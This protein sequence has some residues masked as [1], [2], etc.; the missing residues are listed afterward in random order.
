MTS[1]A[2]RR[3]YPLVV[4]IIA[5]VVSTSIADSKLKRRGRYVRTDVEK[6]VDKDSFSVELSCSTT[7]SLPVLT[8]K[9][10]TIRTIHEVKMYETLI[11]TPH[12]AAETG[13]VFREKNE[14]KVVPGEFM[15]GE[16]SERIEIIDGKP[17]PNEDFSINGIFIFKT[18]ADGNCL[19]K[20]Q[21]ILVFMDDLSVNS[22]TL[23][24][25]HDKLGEKEFVLTRELL[26]RSNQPRTVKPTPDTIPTVDILEAFGLDFTQLR[27]IGR[28]GLELKIDLP[29]GAQPNTIITAT[30]TATNKGNRTIGTLMV[31]T[32]S[33]EGWLDG[34]MFYFGNLEPGKTMT[35][36]RQF[37]VPDK[38][39]AEASHVAFAVWN[40]LGR[41]QDQLQAF[42]LKRR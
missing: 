12:S 26:K 7:G 35:F 14:I 11:E 6:T 41:Q 40:L 16:R 4:A 8:F 10:Q 17:L 31:R 34:K 24:F 18:D 29:E 19:D 27:S 33:R 32:F 37:L 13:P 1:K 22:C 23:T 42:R 20:K 2:Y 3:L 39:A 36:S 15:P 38:A 28:E 25:K 21:R 9:G 5:L 30:V